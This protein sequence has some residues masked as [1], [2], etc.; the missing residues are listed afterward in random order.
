MKTTF[1]TIIIAFLINTAF[2]AGSATDKKTNYGKD[3]KSA[4]KLIKKSK[5]DDAID[6]LMAL[7]DVDTTD[8]TKADVFNEIGFAYR[9]SQDFDNAS[10]YYDKALKLDP[11]HL[12]AL[13]YQGEMY[14]D[15]GQKENALANLEKLRNLVGEKDSY[16]KE[17]NNYI[18]KN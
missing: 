13:E 4:I 1:Y 18:S 6:K 5:Y 11:N 7:V 17:L 3:Y 15:L 8:F 10:K 12:G 14:V 9:K 16:F 2:S